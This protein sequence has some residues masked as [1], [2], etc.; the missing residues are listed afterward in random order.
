MTRGM[1]A[2]DV[3]VFDWPMIDVDI[4]PPVGFY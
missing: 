3:K 4:Y 2:G 1:K